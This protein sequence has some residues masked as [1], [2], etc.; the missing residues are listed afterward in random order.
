MQLCGPDAEL[1]HLRQVN[2]MRGLGFR[3]RDLLRNA[4]ALARRD[5]RG[6]VQVAVEIAEREAPA[7]ALIA[8]EGV[9]DG[10]CGAFARLLD[11]DTA[12][13]RR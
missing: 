12:E 10:D 3:H 1:L 4:G 8:H 6:L 13:Q 5:Q 9:H 7:V 11:L 2:R